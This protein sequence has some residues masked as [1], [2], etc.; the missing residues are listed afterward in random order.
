MMMSK[1]N[2]EQLAQQIGSIKEDPIL[3][4]HER[5]GDDVARKA[6]ELI[7]GNDFIQDAVAYYVEDSKG[8]ELV[9]SILRLL[10]SVAAMNHCYEIYH[11]DG[12]I[13]RRRHALALLAY[14]ADYHAL[15]WVAEFLEHPDEEVNILSIWILD[16]LLLKYEL[17][18]PELFRL[19]LEKAEQHT[20]QRVRSQLAE[21]SVRE[22]FEALFL[23][24][25]S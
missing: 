21:L 11:A 7:L 4:K 6:L 19:M 8:T 23:E 10:R 2:W 13:E 14:I 9:L 5:G 25:N 17:E 12:N 24:S 15:G 16:N 20:S 22:R 1:I 18:Q 3:G